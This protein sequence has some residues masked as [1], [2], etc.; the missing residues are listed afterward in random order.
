MPKTKKRKK[1]ALGKTFIKIYKNKEFKMV[2]VINNGKIGYKVNDQIFKSP[3]GAAKSITE[4]E[5]NG[6]RFWNIDE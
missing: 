3:S 6:W 4:Q 2:V 5:V 1:P